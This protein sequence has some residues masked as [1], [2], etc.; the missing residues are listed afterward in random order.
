MISDTSNY[1]FFYGSLKQ[2]YPTQDQLGIRTAIRFVSEVQTQGDLYD[3]GAYPAMVHG[4]GI[5]YGELYE[6]ADE[7]ALPILD[8]Y[9]G[10]DPDAPASS[11]YVRELLAC[12]ERL[13]WVYIFQGDLL[14]EER[15]VTGIWPK[16]LA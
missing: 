3:L 5:V 14:L 13:A 1:L 10:F 7:Q 9:E 11:L 16:E 6:L 2:A 12:G 15:L 8:E 4:D